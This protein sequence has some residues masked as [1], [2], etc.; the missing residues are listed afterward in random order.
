VSGEFLEGVSEGA[1]GYVLRHIL[2][3][4]DDANAH[5]IL[6]NCRKACAAPGR[7]FVIERLADADGPAAHSSLASEDL[8]MLANVGG[9]ER[10][11]PIRRTICASGAVNSECRLAGQRRRP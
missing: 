2:H 3:D 5:Q 7:V 10:I 6:W 1:G 11:R 4:W 8:E 9:K